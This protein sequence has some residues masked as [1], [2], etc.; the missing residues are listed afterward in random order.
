MA[1]VLEKRD[2]HVVF[3]TIDVTPED[4]ADALQRSYR[5]NVARFAI[6]GFRKGKAPMSLVTKYYGEG[7]L[8]DDAIEFAA[9]PAYAAAV[10]EHGIEP[11]SRPEMDIIDIGRDKGLKFSV[12]VTVKPEATLGQYLGVE[13]V[14][15][16]Y[17]VDEVA[18][19][20]DLARVQERNSRMIPAEDRPIQ[21]G[22][23]AN[24]DYEG[25]LDGVPFDGGKGASYDLKIG[26]KT[27][28]PGFEE[29]LIGHLAGESLELNVTFP[30]D[31]NSEE[32]KGK[33]VVFKTT[34]N[35][36]KIRELPILDD[37]FA[38]DVSEFETLAEYK[39]S[40]RAKLQE[41]SEKRAAGAFEEN[42]IEAVAANAS[43]DIPHVMVDKEIEQMLEE[44]KNQMRYQGIELEQ[45]LGYIGQT[46]DAYKGQMHEPAEHRIKT[47]LVLE[48]VA[49]AEN[50]TA[51]DEEIDAE[52]ERMAAQYN[53]KAEDLRTR[54]Q[55]GNN[56]FV[57]D[58]VIN[59][60][61]VELLTAQAVPIAPKELPPETEQDAVDAI[62]ITDAADLA[63]DTAVAA[64][65]ESAASEEK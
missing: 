17:P 43:V 47:R 54:F 13:A 15:P 37:D 45:Y 63:V 33:A 23:T 60:K 57:R 53:M 42:V 25:F 55:D 19:E 20:R 11:V 5:K 35:S 29:Q 50:I 36:V 10:T 8:Y 2:G 38:K 46:L 28:I 12:S 22:D 40:L 51:A 52:I 58:S 49:K 59:R 32:L 4:F 44:Q 48:A 41:S 64:V 16:E 1:S 9:T 62:D 65:A 6:P 24:I 56:G 61:T 26:S 39:E 31:Y 3:L 27:F 34:V 7:V 14:K 30:E 18:V 21:D